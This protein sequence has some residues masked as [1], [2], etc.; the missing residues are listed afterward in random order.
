[1]GSLLLML[2]FAILTFGNIL[3]NK[4][5]ITSAVQD[6]ARAASLPQGCSAISVHAGADESD[7]TNIPVSRR[8]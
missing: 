7:F 2:V 4:S 1:M 5:A 3:A 6:A 8:A